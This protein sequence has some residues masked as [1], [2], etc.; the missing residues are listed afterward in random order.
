MKLRLNIS[1]CP[2]DTFMFEAMLSHRINTEGLEF[3]VCFADIEQLNS[4]A[5][6]SVADVSKISCATLPQIYKHYA[7][8]DSG[9]ALGRGNGPLLVSRAEISVDNPE[10]R[11]AVPGMNTTANMLMDKLFGQLKNRQPVL[12]SQ[13]AEVVS[14]GEFDAGVLIHEGRFTYAAHGLKLVADLGERW[15]SVSGLPLALGSIVVSRS[16]ETDVQKRVE[17]VLRRSVEYA[18]E[19]PDDSLEFV[20]SHAQEMSVDVMRSH[21]A[22]FVNEFSVALGIDGRRALTELTGLS[23]QKLFIL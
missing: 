15:E 14:R 16:L 21:I 8:L 20:R 3:D 13:I 7:V 18:L 23:D 2:N 12:F 10:L 22:L 11:I 4:M 6:D 1:P 19:H 5:K 9:S 17:R